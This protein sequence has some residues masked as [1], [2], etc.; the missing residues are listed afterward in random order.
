MRLFLKILLLVSIIALG[1]S[2]FMKDRLP[3]EGSILPD[4]QQEPEQRELVMEL[5]NVTAG[6]V[7]YKVTPL[8]E[9]ELWGMVVTYNDSTAWWDYYHKEW[10]D[11]LNLKDL[12]VIWGDNVK[13][14]LYKNFTYKSGGFSCFMNTKPSATREEWESFN[15]HQLSN[16]H[17]ISDNEAIND[18][19]K[20]IGEGDQVHIKGYLAEYKKAGDEHGRGSSTTRE[21]SGQGACETIY[22]TDIEILKE[23]NV[24]WRYT[25]RISKWIILGSTIL[26]IVLFFALPVDW[27][28]KKGER[29]HD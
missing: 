4:L 24:F 2:F 29:K 27:P 20:N 9:Y 17:L 21:D 1:V 5:F 3:S 26:L 18:I 22:V 25:Y 6:D 15:P 23:A 13:N 12:C 14:D 16:N 10:G 7:E 11:Y 8:Y 28:R 19:I